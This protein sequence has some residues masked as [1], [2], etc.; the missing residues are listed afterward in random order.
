MFPDWKYPPGCY[1][2]TTLHCVPRL[3]RRNSQ[4]SSLAQSGW[5][6]PLRFLC[7]WK[8]LL[9][10]SGWHH[11]VRKGDLADLN[12]LHMHPY[13]CTL[14]LNET[15]ITVTPTVPLCTSNMDQ[16][17]TE[18]S[19]TDE[20]TLRNSETMHIAHTIHVP[21]VP[22]LHVCN[23]ICSTSISARRPTVILDMYKL[24]CPGVAANLERMSKK[25]G[26]KT[27]DFS[28]TRCRSLQFL[29]RATLGVNP[30][31]ALQLDLDLMLQSDVI[32]DWNSLLEIQWVIARALHLLSCSTEPK[33]S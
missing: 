6:D 10:L 22:A 1:W 17:E 21:P 25:T 23:K 16:H 33:Q 26:T 31:S 19:C 12:S 5:M 4:W 14:T 15:Y 2:C 30:R 28:P 9:L 8:I 20:Q 11:G 24:W 32:I 29:T 27:S 7:I 13:P 3:C 18:T